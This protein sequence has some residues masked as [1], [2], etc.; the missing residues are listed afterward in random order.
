MYA[1][2]NKDLAA[3]TFVIASGSENSSGGGMF[4]EHEV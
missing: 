3:S 1:D 2:V 4:K